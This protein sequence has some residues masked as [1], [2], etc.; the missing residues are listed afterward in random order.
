MVYRFLIGT[1]TH[2]AQAPPSSRGV[3]LYELDTTTLQATCLDSVMVKNAS[4]V[5]AR[6]CH[7]YALSECGNESLLH[8]IAVNGDTLQVTS[9]IASAGADPCHLITRGNILYA[10]CYSSGSIIAISINGNGT[11]GETVQELQFEHHGT[12]PRQ[13]S[14]HLHNLAL[15]P[16]GDI[17][18]ASNLGGDCIYLLSI[19]HDDTLT[20]LHTLHTAPG[21]GPRH[22]A[23]NHAGT[24]LYVIT[25]LSDEVMALALED[26]KLHYLQTL[27]A[28]RTPGHGAAHIALHPSGKWLYASVRLVD[29]GIAMFDVNDDGRLERRAFYPTGKHPRH[30]AITPCGTMLLT[31]CRDK[32]AIEL[33]RINPDGSLYY[34]NDHDIYVD[35]PVCI[36]M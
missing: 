6:G 5:T 8:S 22:L 30:F 21:S 4:W 11:L 13:L 35:L 24:R 28:A 27:S 36:G 18:A 9:T 14:A 20:L 3:Y 10:A 26:G 12:P 17:M 23:W 2:I 34:L 16:V 7:A 1:Y 33:Y 32:N 29:D 31:A 25:E 19:N 15:T